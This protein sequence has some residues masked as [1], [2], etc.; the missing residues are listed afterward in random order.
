M[1]LFKEFLRDLTGII[2]P[3]MFALLIAAIIGFG[4]LWPFKFTYE[5]LAFLAKIPFST[6]GVILLL[7]ASYI[8]GHYFRLSTTSTVIPKENTQP[9]P[10]V[11]LGNRELTHDEKDT[12]KYNTLEEKYEKIRDN[13]TTFPYPERMKARLNWGYPDGYI[14]FYKK[15]D[16][17]DPSILS[18]KRGKKFH[19][20]IKGRDEKRSN[21][22]PAN[23]ESLLPRGTDTILNFPRFLL[24]K[25]ESLSSPIH[26]PEKS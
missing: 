13:E 14:Q 12:Y 2:F 25:S 1:E 22:I 26:S 5:P 24:P 11:E 9:F 19:E 8:V 23:F 18:R 21:L 16:T 15:F 20:L 7:V 10:T 17:S 4:C 3:G 6:F